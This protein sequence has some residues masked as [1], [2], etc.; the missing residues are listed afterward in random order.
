MKILKLTNCNTLVVTVLGLLASTL[1]IAQ[2]ADGNTGINQA[3]TMLRSYFDSFSNV[4]YALGAIFGLAG[5]IAV[6]RAFTSK[7]HQAGNLAMGLFGGCIFL[8]V[9]GTVLK[10]FFGL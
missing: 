5:S 8:V 7:D 1:S 9:M 6:F 3:N 4:I 10:S 2:T